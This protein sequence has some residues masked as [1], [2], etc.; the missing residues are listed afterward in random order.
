MKMKTRDWAFGVLADA[1][2]AVRELLGVE[3]L[4]GSFEHIFQW[5]IRL[6]A[7]A[8]LN[9]WNSAFNSGRC[10]S[11]SYLMH[12]IG[13]NFG[14]VHSDDDAFICDTYGDTRGMVSSISE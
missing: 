5:Q 12:K 13:H 11:P 2:N 8:T 9:G 1:T 7:F 6:T 4:R 14:L 10:D 3:F